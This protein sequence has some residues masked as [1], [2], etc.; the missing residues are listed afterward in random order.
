ML[1][2]KNRPGWYYEV[3]DLT[4]G[5]CRIIHTDGFSVDDFW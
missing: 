3:I 5:R 4:F 1:E 2:P